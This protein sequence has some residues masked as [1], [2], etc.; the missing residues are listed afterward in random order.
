MVTASLAYQSMTL[1]E[2]A[3]DMR[4][5]GCEDSPKFGTDGNMC[6]AGIKD[7]EME[8]DSRQISAS[9]S[10]KGLSSKQQLHIQRKPKLKSR[11]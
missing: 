9:P 4:H 7:W 6:V 2:E 11:F 10:N 3:K 8:S 5:F 1:G